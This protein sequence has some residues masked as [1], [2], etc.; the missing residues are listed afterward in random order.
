MRPKPVRL[1]LV[2]VVTLLLICQGAA[3]LDVPQLKGRVNDDAGILSS[4]TER[5]L[6]AVLKDLEQTDS[7]QIVVLTL[8]SLQGE[9]LEEF[10]IRVA[11]QWLIGRQ[12][13]DNGVLLLIAVKERKLRIEVGYGL[14]GSLTDLMAGRIIRNVIAPRFKE[15]RFDQGVVDGVAAMIGVVKGEFTPPRQARRRSEG[16]GDSPRGLFLLFVFLIVVNMLGRLRRGMGAVA[17]GVI[18]PIVGAVFFHAGLI[19]LLLLIPIGIIAGLVLSLM[20]SPLIFGRRSGGIGSWGG[21]GFSSGGGFSG[22]GGSF[23]G[24]GASGGW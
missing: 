19:W 15:G 6:D 17:G 11:Q 13:L 4:T 23:G 24:G 1:T 3:A 16:K 21:G 14:E 5:Q 18:A 7:T 20:G 2:V 12:D 22:G 9:N 10:S 8:P